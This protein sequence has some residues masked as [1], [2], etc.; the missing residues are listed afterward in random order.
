MKLFWLVLAVL[1]LVA[2][3]WFLFG[4]AI[5]LFL[6]TPADTHDIRR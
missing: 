1:L 2:Q 4:M 6:F 3:Q 5:G